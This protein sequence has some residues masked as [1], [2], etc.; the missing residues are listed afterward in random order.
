MQT[1]THT[2][3]ASAL[4]VITQLQRAPRLKTLFNKSIWEC[5]PCKAVSICVCVHAD[6]SLS[7]SIKALTKSCARPHCWKCVIGRIA[8]GRHTQIHFI[9]PQHLPYSAAGEHAHKPQQG[10]T[11]TLLAF[12]CHQWQFIRQS[13][14]FYFL[15]S[16]NGRISW[17]WFLQQQGG[18]WW[19]KEEGRE[20]GRASGGTQTG[21]EGRNLKRK[22]KRQLYRE[23]REEGEVK[24]RAKL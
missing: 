12:C 7:W 15:I 10:V 1:H 23:P 19:K 4:T 24:T 6:T 13:I 2:D 18:M 20:E 11:L 14:V 17:I 21:Q 8:K 16:L 5:L 9:D 22:E 3:T